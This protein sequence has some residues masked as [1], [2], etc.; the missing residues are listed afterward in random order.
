MDFVSTWRHPS[1]LDKD[2]P[3]DPDSIRQYVAEDNNYRMLRKFFTHP[4]KLEVGNSGV[5]FV[6]SDRYAPPNRQGSITLAQA[7]TFCGK[8][9]MLYGATSE[10][11]EQDAVNLLWPSYFKAVKIE[12]TPAQWFA[13]FS[14]QYVNACDQSCPSTLPE[15]VEVHRDVLR[16]VES[17]MNGVY[18]AIEAG[19][20]QGFGDSDHWQN[21][22]SYGPLLP[23]LQEWFVIVNDPEK[24][25]ERALLVVLRQERAD[26]FAARF[27]GVN[28]EKVSIAEGGAIWTARASLRKI[29][30]ISIAMD[31]R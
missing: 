27:V 8:A 5:D 23:S 15:W 11:N 20:E 29:M 3:R 6:S 14:F 13:K 24:P 7:H 28:M 1:D 30:D 12:Y 26:A 17:S 31:G 4:L 19:R 9:A 22:S 18:D 21:H 25:M 2:A 10:F 16:L